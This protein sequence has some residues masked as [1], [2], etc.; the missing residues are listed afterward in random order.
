MCWRA[1]S[2]K[3]ITQG[4]TKAPVVLSHHPAST[5]SPALYHKCHLAKGSWPLATM[6]AFPAWQSQDLW[7]CLAASGPEGHLPW[8][9]T[10]E[11]R[12]EPAI[13]V[14]TLTCLPPVPLV[15]ACLS[16][17]TFQLLQFLLAMTH[18]GLQARNPHSVSVSGSFSSEV[19][20]RSL[21][22]GLAA[23]S[24]CTAGRCG[25]AWWLE[26]GL[27]RQHVWLS[28]LCPCPPPN[29]SDDAADVEGVDCN[30]F[31]SFLTLRPQNKHLW[32]WSREMSCSFRAA[33][34]FMLCEV[35]WCRRSWPFGRRG[36]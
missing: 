10:L 18:L 14:P 5:L 12:I 23:L 27:T 24:P 31:L 13:P 21:A 6:S 11:A 36:Y 22:R 32:D 8:P 30:I 7:S 26:T 17:A 2:R 33:T 4:P 3:R 19:R 28:R 29:R 1:G 9:A 15:H 16:G 25:E 20:G 34:N 35:L